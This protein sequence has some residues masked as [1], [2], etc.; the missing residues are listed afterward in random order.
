[1]RK[2]GRKREKK[3]RK[4]SEEDGEYKNTLRERMKKCL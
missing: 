3:D 4:Y 1:V 2:R